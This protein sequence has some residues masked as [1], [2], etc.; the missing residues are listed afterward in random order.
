MIQDYVGIEVG[1]M[2]IISVSNT[3]SRPT[4]WRWGESNPRPNGPS[5]NVYRLRSG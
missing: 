3:P 2:T 4:I 1:Y 5:I